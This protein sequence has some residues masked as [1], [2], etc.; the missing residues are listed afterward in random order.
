MRKVFIDGGAYTGTST[1]LFLAKYPESNEYEIHCFE[2]HPD[3]IGGGN[4]PNLK[5]Y[6]K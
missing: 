6:K 3:L 4:R 1:D 5:N 2:A